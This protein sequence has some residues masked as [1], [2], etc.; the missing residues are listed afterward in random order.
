MPFTSRWS[1]VYLATGARGVSTCGDFLTATALAL[2]LQQ[3]GAGGMAVS[4]LLLAAGLPL[5]L[6]APVAGRIADRADSRTVLV[7][8]GLAQAAVCAALAFTSSP[9]VIIGLVALLACGLAITQPTL[10]ALLPDMVRRPDLAR[11]TGL[12]QT[13]AMVGMLA[14]PALAGLLVGQFGIRV[15]LLLDAASYLALV[16][17]GLLIRT[18]RRSRPVPAADREAWR[19]T[20]D[21][22]VTTM[23]VAVAA[24]VAGVGAINVVQVFFIRDTLDASTTVFGLVSASWTAGMMVG[25]LLFG[26]LLRDAADAGRLVRLSLL[27]MGVLCAMVGAAAGVGTVLVLVPLW[28][29]GGLCNGGLN[30]CTN[31]V[32]AHRVP[33]GTRGRAFATMGS[34]VQGAGMIGFLVAGPLVDRFDPRVLVLAAG[35]AG[36]AA[37]LACVPP[38]RRAVRSEP[39]ADAVPRSAVLAGDSVGA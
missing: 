22:L 39:P 12:N 31:L 32:I 17:A 1:D 9:V 3:A 38:V 20:S 4:G 33:A 7:T 29:V 2:W 19:M 21:R 23:V 5:V 15:P 37:V 10:A 25:G 11:A 35:L 16:A 28:V 14:A 26:R 36:L 8:A 24:V 30:V 27:L 18:R 6:L 13:A 34:A